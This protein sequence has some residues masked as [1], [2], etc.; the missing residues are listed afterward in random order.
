MIKFARILLVPAFLFLAIASHA[1]SNGYA[2]N[3]SAR[4]SPDR[5]NSVRVSVARDANEIVT[6][7]FTFVSD[8]KAAKSNPT[9]INA[10]FLKIGKSNDGSLM[11]EALGAASKLSLPAMNIEKGADDGVFAKP[12][13]T[14]RM[15]PGAGGLIIA[16]KD[17]GK[18][19]TKEIKLRVPQAN[20]TTTAE[21]RF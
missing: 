17:L 20:G 5:T 16:I 19:S 1:Q 8:G 3:A 4:T 11:F 9:E 10:Q 2:T 12:S 18:G 13:M 7:G 15:A 14:L 6:V 21:M